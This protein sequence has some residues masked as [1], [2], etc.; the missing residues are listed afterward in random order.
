LQEALDLSF[1]ITD[2]DDDDDDDDIL[3]VSPSSKCSFFHN[4]N[5]FGSCIIHILYTG[6]AKIKKNNSDAKRLIRKWNWPFV[7]GGECKSHIS[8]TSEI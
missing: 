8:A 2:D 6:R 5:V 1:D 7:N 3:S 4:S